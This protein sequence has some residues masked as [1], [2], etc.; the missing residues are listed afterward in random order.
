MS[1]AE[2]IREQALSLAASGADRDEAIRALERAAEGR[3]VA[4]VRARQEVTT[5]LETGAE[6]PGAA[7]AIELL[8][9]V[10]VHLP[11]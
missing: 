3:R 9:E 11:A 7:R 1:N 5:S 10:L 6:E 2:A 4:V 8:D